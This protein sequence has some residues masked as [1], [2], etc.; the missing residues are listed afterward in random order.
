MTP[1]SGKYNQEQN[2]DAK[3]KD[4]SAR[5]K[6]GVCVRRLLYQRKSS[7]YAFREYYHELDKE[8]RGAEKR[9]SRIMS[10]IK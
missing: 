3:R 6:G 2:L 8:L 10:L 4:C 5:K 9:C 7:M 1:T